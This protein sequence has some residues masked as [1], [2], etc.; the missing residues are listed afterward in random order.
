MLPTPTPLRLPLLALAAALALGG[1]AGGPPH[2]RH[3][4]PPERRGDDPARATPLQ[5]QRFELDGRPLLLTRLP[6]APARQ[7]V[8]VYL[9]GLGQ[10]AA[11]GQRWQAAWAAAGYAVL[12]VQPR[13][14]DAGAWRSEL[15]RSGE[16]RELGRLHHGEAAQRERVAALARLVAA[17]RATPPWAGLDWEHA[18]LAGY[19]IGAQTVLDWPAAAD[20][21]PRGVI[22]ISPPPM[23]PATTRPALFVTSDLDGDP[24][25]LVQQPAER[26][27]GFD[28]LA[29]GRAW[30]LLLPGVSHAGLS[31]TP[32]SDAWAEQDERRGGMP[33]GGLGA[34]AGRGG[35]AGGLAGGTPL[36]GPRS[37]SATEAAQAELGE[38]L[39]LSTGMLDAWLRGAPMPTGPQLSVR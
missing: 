34:R 15:A 30:L 23:R 17:L 33:G 9:P 32:V 5:Y 26:R 4:P 21:Q 19:D 8:V 13:E 29:P 20:W 11:A 27:Q 39:R 25:G 37:G 6:A 35:A 22:A 16:F 31:G 24:L 10:D 14:A 38:A 36:R 12:A 7:P 1:C 3:G 18:V 28:A 2:G